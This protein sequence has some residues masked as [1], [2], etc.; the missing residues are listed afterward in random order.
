MLQID[1]ILNY[2]LT[3]SWIS[4]GIVEPR[5]D[6]FVTFVELYYQSEF[7]CLSQHLEGTWSLKLV[8]SFAFIWQ[9]DKFDCLQGCNTVVLYPELKQILLLLAG[10]L[11]R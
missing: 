6:N 9:S 4:Y 2:R 11:Q 8:W 10:I 5:L 7:L 1:N 3:G